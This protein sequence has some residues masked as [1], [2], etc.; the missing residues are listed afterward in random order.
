MLLVCVGFSAS[1]W[2]M[3]VP[4]PH[5]VAGGPIR[6][7]RPQTRM[8]QELKEPQERCPAPVM[9]R[10]KHKTKNVDL[11]LTIQMDQRRNSHIKILMKRQSF[12]FVSS[13]VGH[14]TLTYW[15]QF[16]HVSSSVVTIYALCLYKLYNSSFVWHCQLS[17]HVFDIIHL[18]GFI[19]VDLVRL[20]F[21]EEKN[22]CFFYVLENECD[23]N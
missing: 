11:I 5:A 12:S 15:H 10:L 19:C 1:G 17:L 21:S 18:Q 23:L 20:V 9:V 22:S 3:R 4:A 2:W 13:N 7:F 16:Q 8:G 6:L 14:S